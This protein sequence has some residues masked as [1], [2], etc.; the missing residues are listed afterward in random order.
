MANSIAG[1][2]PL[3]RALC[4]DSYAH[5]AGYFGYKRNLDA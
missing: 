5:N 1:L 3:R 4:E 2:G